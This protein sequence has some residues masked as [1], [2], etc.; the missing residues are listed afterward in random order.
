MSGIVR[1]RGVLSA[2]VSSSLSNP[3]VLI[4]AFCLRSFI[5]MMEVN[6]VSMLFLNAF[7]AQ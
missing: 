3:A 2:C 4:S 7:A 1:E 5:A 6:G